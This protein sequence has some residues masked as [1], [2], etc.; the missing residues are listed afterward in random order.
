MK[1]TREHILITRYFDEFDTSAE[2]LAPHHRRA[3]EEGLRAHLNEILPQDASDDEVAD[4]LEE[5]GTPAQILADEIQASSAPS[6]TRAM[7]IVWLI[8]VIIGWIL[9]SLNVLQM[10]IGAIVAFSRN[11]QLVPG[12]Y[13]VG[14]LLGLLIGVGL[15]LLGYQGRR[16]TRRG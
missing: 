12:W 4:A 2:A 10:A 8:V 15:L 7:R 6:R 9:V 5:L 3:I 16:R 14:M 1:T 11:D 13:W